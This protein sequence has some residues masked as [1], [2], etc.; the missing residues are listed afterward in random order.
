MQLL[1]GLQYGV[2]ATFIYVYLPPAFGEMVSSCGLV[3]VGAGLVMLPVLG[4]V[5]YAAAASFLAPLLNFWALNHVSYD[6]DELWLQIALFI[7][8]GELGQEILQD[9]ATKGAIPWN[10]FLRPSQRYWTTTELIT[11]QRA[12]TLRENAQGR[13]YPRDSFGRY[14]AWQ[15]GASSQVNVTRTGSGEEPGETASPS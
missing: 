9:A 6:E 7:L 3:S 15:R 4:V 12:R 1:T 2:V 14:Y 13:G 11:A 8:R 5:T 10:E